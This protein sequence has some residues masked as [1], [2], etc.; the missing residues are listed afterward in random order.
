MA[1]TPIYLEVGSKKV[2]ACAL[3]WPGWCRAAH[4][5]EVAMQALSDYAVRYAEVAKAAGV[6]FP[7]SAG[8]TFEVVERLAG[9]T[10]TDF[11]APDIPARADAATLTAAQARRAA[12]LVEASWS[13][14]E[15]VAATAPA[16][17]RKGPR[18]GGRDRDDV[19]AHVAAAEFA[20]ARKIGVRHRAAGDGRDE[21]AA[22][23]ALRADVLAAL[24]AAR[25][26]AP[27]EERGWPAR[28]AARRIAWHALDH[29]WE[30]EDRSTPG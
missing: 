10:T 11:G 17:L 20:Y 14:L 16:V 22:V 18:G 3:D 4:I 27:V 21:R 15:A 12:A 25:S 13:V 1:P 30:I 24:R 26:G 19:V 9:S 5:E 2:F 6:R 8:R 7:P 23:A 29:A 28:Y